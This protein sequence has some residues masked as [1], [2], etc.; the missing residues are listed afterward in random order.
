M[1]HIE[2]VRHVVKWHKQVVLTH[3]VQ[4]DAQLYLVQVMLLDQV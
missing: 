4:K 3:F 1:R 2:S